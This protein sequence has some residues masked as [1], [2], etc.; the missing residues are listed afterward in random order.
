MQALYLQSKTAAIPLSDALT[1]FL[2]NAF[3]SVSSGRLV[4]S[5]AGAGKSTVFQVPRVDQ[6]LSQEEI[7]GLS[8]ELTDVYNDAVLTLT[9][10]AANAVPPVTADLSDPTVYALMTQDIR[11]ADINV[12][13]P[14]F[15]N[16]LV[17]PR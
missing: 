14:D 7:F 11:L 6:Y 12:V 8:Q 3:G 1:S 4:V 2:L 9:D 13:Q 5:H 17:W 10:I 16:L 15:T